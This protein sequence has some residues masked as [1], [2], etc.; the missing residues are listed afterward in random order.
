MFSIPGP[1]QEKCGVTFIPLPQSQ[2]K[3]T[4]LAFL[5]LAIMTFFWYT[6][7]LTSG[8]SKWCA[9]VRVYV[10]EGSES[11]VDGGMLRKADKGKVA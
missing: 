6:I 2:Q 8:S 9:Q 3:F 10:K 4:T 5:G 1:C 7:T 11:M